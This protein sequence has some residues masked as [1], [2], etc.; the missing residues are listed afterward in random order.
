MSCTLPLPQRAIVEVGCGNLGLSRL[1]RSLGHIGRNSF[2][3]SGG[4]RHKIAF[5]RKRPRR[6]ID[7]LSNLPA[8][9]PL[10]GF[11]EVEKHT[12]RKS[13]PSVSLAAP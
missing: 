13:F 1:P 5:G 7:R 8:P 10:P 12:C 11:V 4:G 2:P 6:S 3:L 9:G